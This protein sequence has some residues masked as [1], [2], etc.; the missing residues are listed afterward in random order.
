M[1]CMT[2][3]PMMCMHYNTQTNLWGVAK[4]PW[5]EKYCVGG[6]SGGS[7]GVISTRCAPLAI[8]SDL[9]GSIRFP[10]AWNGI[11]GFKPTNSRISKRGD[12]SLEQDRDDNYGK[13]VTVCFGPMGKC[14]DDMLLVCQ[15]TFG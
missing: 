7:A 10:S 14:S 11:Y 8:G 3:T 6:S 4:N 5:N 9:A 13:T 1:L 15:S 12:I 2:T